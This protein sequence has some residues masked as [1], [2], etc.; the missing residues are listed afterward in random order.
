MNQECIIPVPNKSDVKHAESKRRDTIR[1]CFD[2]VIREAKKE[3]HEDHD[4]SLRPLFNGVRTIPLSI[5][6]LRGGS[7]T[8][9]DLGGGNTVM[10]LER[11][12]EKLLSSVVSNRHLACGIDL[13]VCEMRM[14][15]RGSNTMSPCKCKCGHAEVEHMPPDP[16]DRMCEHAE[17]TY[18]NYAS[19]RTGIQQ[20]REH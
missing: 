12:D 18:W 15:R 3:I 13:P 11:T 8:V 5:Q 2:V 6:T 1:F 14:G 9:N 16:P 19:V 7:K 4:H 10:V 20:E 17:C